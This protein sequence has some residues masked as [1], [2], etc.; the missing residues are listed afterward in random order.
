MLQR[1]IPLLPEGA[2]P[3][4]DHIAIFC[5]QGEIIF[6][7]AS[8]AI[9]KCSDND[10]YGIRLAQGILCSA[11]A[12][13][14]AQL[15]RA[16]GLNRSTVCRNKA[17]YEQGG[18]QALL[19]DKSSNRSSYK[20]DEEKRRRAQ[21][22][23][24]QA[25]SVKKIGETVGVTEGCIRYAIRKGILVRK[26]VIKNQENSSFRKREKVS[27]GYCKDDLL[28]FGDLLD[29]PALSSLCPWK[30]GRPGIFEKSLSTAC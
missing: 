4:N 18:A 30:R 27:L 9:F 13:R 28:S 3:V 22:L 7:N 11:N 8:S 16:L 25:V 5:G 29:Q 17:A 21:N 23:L 24:D 2:K 20:L 26:G 15:A 14:P 10:Q 6:L 12:V 1:P 19:I